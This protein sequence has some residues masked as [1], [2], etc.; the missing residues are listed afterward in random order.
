MKLNAVSSKK[1]KHLVRDRDLIS[2]PPTATVKEASELMSEKNIGAL[3]IMEG[4]KMVGILS[5][6]DIVQRCIGVQG[7]DPTKQVV[8]NIMSH[9]VITI[10]RNLSLGVA[11]VI[12]MEQGIRH[13][14]VV[15]DQR[16]LGMISL[17]QVV[18]EFRKGLESSILRLAA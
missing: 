5:E 3:A 8:S 18:E 12:M 9:P 4:T 14:P 2:L 7:C 17:R 10:D 6:R 16:V 1:V 15:N 11:V 13:L